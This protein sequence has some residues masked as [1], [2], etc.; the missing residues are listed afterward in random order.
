MN[1]SS[2][3]F[4]RLFGLASTALGLVACA[5][6]PRPV[7]PTP[8]QPVVP[9]SWSAPLPHAG[10]TVAL[11]DWWSQFDDAALDRLI[12][13]S[14]SV[15]ADLAQ[16]QARIAQARAGVVQAQASAEP[17]VGAGGAVVRGRETFDGPTGL[18]LSG[19]LQASWELDLWGGL[20]AGQRA[21]QARLA[22]SDANWNALRVAVAAETAAQ[23]INA[24]A[25]RAF[26]R[27]QALELDSRTETLRLT[28]LG[29]G[30]GLRAPADTSLA[31]AAM[32]VAQGALFE[33]QTQCAQLINTLA[34]LTGEPIAEL[35]A[36]VGS[37]DLSRPLPLPQGFMVPAIPGE[38]LRQRPDLQAA[39]LEWLA[40][41]AEVEQADARF[42][43]QVRFSGLLSVAQLRGAGLSVSGSVWTLGPLEISLPLADGGVRQAGS[44]LARARLQEADALFQASIRRAVGEV[45][46]ALIVLERWQAREEQAR[47]AVQGLDQTLAA[48][49]ARWR[50]GLA[51]QFEL[52]EIRRQALQARVQ[53]IDLQRARVQAWISLYR[54]LGGGWT[55]ES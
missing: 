24:R 21:A 44:D 40:R 27:V 49:E 26:E 8:P 35:E 28:R 37:A 20:A 33:R 36:L 1:V 54:A 31:Q 55:L 11:Q 3:R 9:P 45:Q 41:L 14:Q 34:V 23:Y 32:A 18:R 4:M 6:V 50:A 42:R 38:L 30:A 2:S 46:D 19:S 29:E 7:D 51:S 39:E 5:S 16:A 47:L 53:I 15:S 48:T 12:L 22:A 25:C 10:S 52:E 17:Q 13:A 43:P